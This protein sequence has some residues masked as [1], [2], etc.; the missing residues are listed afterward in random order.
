MSIAA[1]EKE[2][3]IANYRNNTAANAIIIDTRT[4]PCPVPT[5]HVEFSLNGK[6]YLVRLCPSKVLDYPELSFKIT[7]GTR[8]ES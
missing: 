5:Y 7:I 4:I 3:L 8:V 1:R 2:K 6:S